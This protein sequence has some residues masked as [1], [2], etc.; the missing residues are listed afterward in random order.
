MVVNFNEKE[1]ELKYTFNSFK[2]MKNFSTKM[3]DEVNEKPFA[4]IDALEVLLMGA[5]NNDKKVK[6]T[7]EDVDT[8]LEDISNKGEL[9]ELLEQ[10][11]E[12]LQESGF[13]KG[14]QKEQN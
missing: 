10:L 13:F 4:I 11:M 1:I 7:L 9:P 8:I 3:F 14:L 2:Y 5:I 12:L 6:Y